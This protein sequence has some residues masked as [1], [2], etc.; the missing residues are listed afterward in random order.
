M[1]YLFCRLLYRVVIKISCRASAALNPSAHQDPTMLLLYATQVVQPEHQ[2]Y[3]L[4]E[5]IRLL[6]FQFK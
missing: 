6:I 4:L 5:A 1:Q 2:R 3:F